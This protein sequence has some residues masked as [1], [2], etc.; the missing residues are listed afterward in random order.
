VGPKL[1]RLDEEGRALPDL[2]VRPAAC[3]S[4]GEF[5]L[6]DPA[7]PGGCAPGGCI[8]GRS[9]RCYPKEHAT[10]VGRFFENLYQCLCC[11]DPCYEPTWV[12]TA[13]AAFFVDP[14]RP[15]TYMRLRWDDGHNMLFPDRSEYFWARSY[16]GPGP[17]PKVPVTKHG[18][19]VFGERS[20]N[21]D[22]LALYMEAA[23]QRFS[24]FTEFP[25][26][27]TFPLLTPHHAGFSD[28]NLG[29]KSLLLDCDLIQFTFQ[30]RTYI[31][32][33]SVSGGLS[34]GHVSL[35][36]S[37]LMALHLA[38]ETYFQGQLSE[39]IPLGG[40]PNY[41]G[42]ILHYHL[43][44]NQTLCRLHP[45]VPLI[46]TLEFN[47]WSFQDGAFT[48]PLR[49]PQKSSGA[50]Y[51]SLGPGLRMSVCKNIDFGIGTAFSLG[52]PNWADSLIRSDVRIFY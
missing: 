4:C 52:S 43:S 36:P 6:S 18:R 17:Q 11:P 48:A 27:T 25:Y 44:L 7:F 46:G 1:V 8:P 39:W 41:A 19:P 40:D 9:N 37:F 5:H 24:F 12:P 32:M 51:F 14:A 13:N 2:D 3:A 47:G 26:R 31:P 35:E 30:F 15:R 33:G 22:Q 28:M 23:V 16:L 38:P 20:L 34:N 10:F 29:T 21:Y 42:A 45:D 49:G 50:S